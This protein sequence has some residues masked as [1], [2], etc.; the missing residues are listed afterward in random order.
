[1]CD[2][3]LAPEVGDALLE[4]RLRGR[5]KNTL[6]LEL[7]NQVETVRNGVG[8]PQPGQIRFA[9]VGAGRG[10]GEVWLL[11]GSPRNARRRI[12]QPLRLQSCDHKQS[13]CASER[14]SLEHF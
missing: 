10:R 6:V 14:E 9:V 8:T 7:L 13:G 3:I 5:Q 2:R 1:M 11:V 4:E 12:V